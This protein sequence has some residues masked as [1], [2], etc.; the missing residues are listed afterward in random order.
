MDNKDKK[1]V[2]LIPEN[3]KYIQT[4]Q[5]HLIANRIGSGDYHVLLTLLDKRDL[6]IPPDEVEK[7][8]GFYNWLKNHGN[9]EFYD[10]VFKEFKETL[11]SKLDNMVKEAEKRY[12]RAYFSVSK[13]K[14]LED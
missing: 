4:F 3:E 7:E 12:E 9:Y 1:E 8:G 2:N 5:E 11:E 14:R 10:S 13:M 6:K